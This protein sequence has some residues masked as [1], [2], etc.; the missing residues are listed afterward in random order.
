MAAR[1]CDIQPEHWP[2]EYTSDLIDLLNVLGRL[3]TLEPQQAAL[4]DA[5]LAGD[6]E[7]NAKLSAAGAL[8]ASQDN[9]AD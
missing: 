6:L 9:G 3:V 8:A 4:L 7:D 5:I 1:S 2:H